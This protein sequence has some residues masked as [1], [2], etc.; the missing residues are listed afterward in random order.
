MVTVVVSS[1]AAALGLLFE[2][3]NPEDKPDSKLWKEAGHKLWVR[4]AWIGCVFAVIT[5]FT[6]G[7]KF[8]YLAA[9]LQ[10]GHEVALTDI[11]QKALTVL[12]QELDAMIEVAAVE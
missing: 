10:V 12:E 3:C 1:I 2:F 8:L 6:P 7:E 11:G 9:G 5:A 4:G